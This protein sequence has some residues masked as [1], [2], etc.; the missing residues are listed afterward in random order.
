MRRLSGFGWLELVIG[1]LLI[2]LGVF[3]FANPGF[4]LTGL[5]A[6]ASASGPASGVLLSA[7]SGEGSGAGASGASSR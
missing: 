1:I 3:T 5:A 6:G 4:A 2:V 7:A